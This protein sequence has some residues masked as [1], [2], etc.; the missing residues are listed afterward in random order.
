MDRQTNTTTFRAPDG[1][2]N[3]MLRKNSVKLNSDAAEPRTSSRS[4]SLH[5]KHQQ[6]E[7]RDSGYKVSAIIRLEGVKKYFLFYKE[8]AIKKSVV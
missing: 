5:V 2:K 4:R 7:K 1:A 8:S 6:R 3:F